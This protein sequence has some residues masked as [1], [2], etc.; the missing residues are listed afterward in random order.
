MTLTPGDFASLMRKLAEHDDIE[1]RHVQMDKLLCRVLESL[2]YAE[3]VAI[4]RESEK[5]YS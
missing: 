5:W 2:G 1:S 3:G 4:F